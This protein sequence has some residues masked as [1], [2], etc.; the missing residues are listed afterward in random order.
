MN[1]IGELIE[2]SAAIC[3]DVA[4]FAT[5]ANHRFGDLAR[6]LRNLAVKEAPGESVVPSTIERARARVEAARHGIRLGEDGR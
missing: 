4:A 3:D 2:T 5:S 1:T 6:L